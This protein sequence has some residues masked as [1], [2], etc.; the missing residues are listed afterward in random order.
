MPGRGEAVYAMYVGLLREGL[1]DAMEF[2]QDQT[3]EALSIAYP[4]PSSPGEYPHRRTGNLQRNVDKHEAE[5]QGPF[6]V[7]AV[8]VDL[9]KVDYAGHLEFGTSK[10][11]ARPFL[12]PSLLNNAEAIKQ[13]IVSKVR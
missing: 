1:D 8:G 10:M 6:L 2:L 4:P 11:A 7:G 13:R 3:Q 12:R 9:G 5:I